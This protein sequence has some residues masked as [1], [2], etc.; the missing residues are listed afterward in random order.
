M[1]G[2]QEFQ[3]EIELGSG[4]K[5]LI[6]RVYTA[7]LCDRMEIFWVKNASTYYTTLYD[8]Y[9]VFEPNYEKTKEE[10]IDVSA[11]MEETADAIAGEI[12]GAQGRC[13]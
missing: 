8:D 5:D 13:V 2:I 7:V 10:A 6:D 4:D 3:E 12:D 9:A 1:K 11:Q